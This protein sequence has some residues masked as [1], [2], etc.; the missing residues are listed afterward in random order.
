[1]I[2]KKEASFFSCIYP[3][4]LR[5]EFRMT[6]NIELQFISSL[7]LFT[8]ADADISNFQCF[9]I[10]QLLSCQP[11]SISFLQFVEYFGSLKRLA[12]RPTFHSAGP[13]PQIL[14][15]FLVLKSGGCREVNSK[16]IQYCTFL[17]YRCLFYCM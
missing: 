9:L 8:C 13:H 14:W 12:G 5:V 7:K 4:S 11:L 15:S 3:I 10:C 1:M 2:L 6:G 17:F 16:H